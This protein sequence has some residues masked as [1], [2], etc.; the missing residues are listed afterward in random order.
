MPNL[1]KPKR[2]ITEWKKLKDN[3]DHANVKVNKKM[4][5]KGMPLYG[6]KKPIVLF[7]MHEEDAVSDYPRAKRGTYDGNGTK[8]EKTKEEKAKIEQQKKDGTYEEDDSELE[9]TVANQVMEFEIID[10]DTNEAVEIKNLKPG[11]LQICM[12]QKDKKQKIMY[13]NEKNEQLQSDGIS[14]NSDEEIST[15]DDAN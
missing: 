14:D 9:D 13:L 7:N 6:V 1:L 11:M 8:I 15:R 5:D 3:S 2:L 10:G 4:F 12:I